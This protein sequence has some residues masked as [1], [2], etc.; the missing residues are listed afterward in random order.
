MT[1]ASTPGFTGLQKAAVL[2]ASLGVERSS[3][4]LQN[5]GEGELE[6]VL[7]AVSQAGTLTAGA[8]RAVLQEAQGLATTGVGMMSRGIEYTRQLLARAVGPQ[9]SAEIL[10]RIA[11][12]QQRSA[13]E[14][15]RDT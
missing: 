10:E 15:V 13:F 2:L 5:L 6:R 9:L 7:L 12:S 1:E 14:I 3:G 8:R 4:V 11:E